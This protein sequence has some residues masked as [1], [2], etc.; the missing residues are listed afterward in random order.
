M[1]ELLPFNMIVTIPIQ[2]NERIP[3]IYNGIPEVWSG[4]FWLRQERDRWKERGY[5]AKVVSFVHNGI[6]YEQLEQYGEIE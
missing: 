5:D 2:P 1:G 4:K 6:L 3:V